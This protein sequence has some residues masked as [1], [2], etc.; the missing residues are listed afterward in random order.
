MVLPPSS[1]RAW[2]CG[3]RFVIQKRSNRNACCVS[4]NSICML[5]MNHFIWRIRNACNANYFPRIMNGLSGAGIRF[6]S[7][8]VTSFPFIRRFRCTWEPKSSPLSFT[9]S[10]CSNSIGYSSWDTTNPKRTNQAIGSAVKHTSAGIAP[11]TRHAFEH[12]ISEQMDPKPWRTNWALSPDSSG[13]VVSA[14]LYTYE[15]AWT[16]RTLVLV[17]PRYISQRCSECGTIE[18]TY[19][20]A[21]IR[22]NVGASLTGTRMQLLTSCVQ[23]TTF[24]PGRGQRRQ[25]RRNLWSKAEGTY[26]SKGIETP[27]GSTS[28]LQEPHS[29]G[30]YPQ[31][32]HTEVD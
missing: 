16:G 10:S 27:M 24:W 21:G 29:W 20:S 31:V 15:A 2:K 14:Q 4:S 12:G 19:R 30:R 17:N 28:H 6:R 3:R 8:Q 32:K 18:K 23:L 26:Q 9:L 1:I 13:V 25:L 5:D 22:A 7:R 11:A